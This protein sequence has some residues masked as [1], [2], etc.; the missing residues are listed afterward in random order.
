M[1]ISKSLL[2]HAAFISLL[3]GLSLTGLVVDSVHKVSKYETRVRSKNDDRTM[4]LSGMTLSSKRIVL[5]YNR[6][7]GDSQRVETSKLYS[8]S[9]VSLNSLE[10]AGSRDLSIVEFAHINIHEEGTEI[11]GDIGLVATRASYARFLS[12]A[13]AGLFGL[14]AALLLYF[15]RDPVCMISRRPADCS[16]SD[17][18][19]M[20]LQNAL[21]LVGA[22]ALWLSMAVYSSLVPTLL[23]HMFREGRDRCGIAFDSVYD[24]QYEMRT[25]GYYVRDHSQANGVSIICFAAAFSL[26]LA[27]MLFMFL[28]DNGQPLSAQELAPSQLRGLP[29]YSRV[30]SW[31]VTVGVFFVAVALTFQIA[32]LTRERGFELNQFYWKYGSKVTQKTGLSRTGTLLDVVQKAIS[33]VSLSDSVV[34]GSAYLWFALVPAIALACSRPLMLLAKTIQD[35]SILLCVR[36]LI[37]WVTIAP[38]SLSM[39]EKPEC[40]EPPSPDLSDWAWLYIMDPSQSCNDTMFS[41]Y[42]VFILMPA[43]LLMF[44]IHYAE[45]ADHAVAVTLYV[46][47]AASA[48]AASV[49]VVVSRH[50]YTADVV[51]GACVVASYLLTQ[52]GPYKVLFDGNRSDTERPRQ[53]LS[54]KILPALEE[55]VHR[56]QTYGTASTT[57]RG[58]KA[59]T[60]EIEEISLLYRTVGEAM[61]RVR[62]PQTSQ[63]SEKGIAIPAAD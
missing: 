55:C 46:L 14:S 38:T 8:A 17:H 28:K 56:V 42:V 61:R 7:D 53:I 6:C 62:N 34:A 31:K 59:S 35:V 18:R 3:T 39:M 33:L 48:L 13:A 63:T 20:L 15:R 36:A 2:I 49:I 37:A 52:A 26:S 40:F 41:L 23:A 9:G 29:W 32:N 50:Q 4:K 21:V 57:L 30:W 54:E 45:V 43:M 60:D 1:G 25:M 58:L 11:I 24:S 16:A 19:S 22:G 12:I 5:D 27:Y 51:I 47:I 10:E 44:Y